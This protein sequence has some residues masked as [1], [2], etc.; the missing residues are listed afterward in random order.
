M[1]DSYLAFFSFKLLVLR[2]AFPLIYWK[3]ARLTF[4][5]SVDELPLK[6]AVL[7]IIGCWSNYSF[8]LFNG[9]EIV[10]SFS[11]LSKNSDVAG[12]LFLTFPRLLFI[13]VEIVLPISL[14][15]KKKT[16]NFYQKLLPRD[17]FRIEKFTVEQFIMLN[18]LH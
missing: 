6:L 14:P 16:H 7:I 3:L 12:W 4:L 11:L 15:S 17:F 9:C 8:C 18:D 5:A 2:L 1:C 10:V 13:C